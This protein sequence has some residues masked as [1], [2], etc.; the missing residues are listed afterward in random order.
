MSELQK[1]LDEADTVYNQ[2]IKQM[3]DLRAQL[4][5]VGRQRLGLRIHRMKEQGY[6]NVEIG[7]AVGLS[8]NSVRLILEKT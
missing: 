3:N 7:T 4:K 8:E 2:L 1:K 5:L 6:S